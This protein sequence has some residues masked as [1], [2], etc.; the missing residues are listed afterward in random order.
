MILLYRKILKV[1]FKKMNTQNLDP[2]IKAN[3]ISAYLLLFI[4]G[5]FLFNKDNP[6]L[7]NSF[8]KSHTKVALLIHFWF[9]FTY[10]VFISFW[11]GFDFSILNYSLNQIIATSIFIILFI[12]LLF[13]M[14][15]A[16]SWEEFSLVQTVK[17]KNW[18]LFNRKE[19]NSFNEKDKLSVILSRTPFVGFLIYPK[20]KDSEIIQ[21]STKLNMIIT[22][23]IFVLYVFWN[24]NLAT[25]LLLAYIIVVVF[26]SINLITRSEVV[27][28]NLESI[29]DLKETRILIISVFKYLKLYFSTKDF[30]WFKE[31]FEQVKNEDEVRL[32]NDEK[33]LNE[34]ADFKLPSIITYIPVLNIISLFN[35]NSKLQ[36]HII[37]GLVITSLFILSWIF[38]WFS[39][40]IQLLLLFPLFFGVWHL[41]TEA[42]YEIPFL[43]DIYKILA[44]TIIKT[45]NLF[46]FLHKKHKE[47]K[48]E[49]LKVEE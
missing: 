13:W 49:T 4:S 11:L 25:L 29:P 30:R 23:I 35:L 45:K 5:T 33:Y 27:N 28:I 14:Y 38:L 39:N 36:K 37:N 21:N 2:K 6:L 46:S 7:N 18:N 31:I 40:K 26:L 12:A 10:I 20:L 48:S 32:N 47:E 9:L 42:S 43:H 41:K 34:K 22:F 15:K 17:L 3:A 19:E 8:V 24:P 1:N 44:Y 16:S